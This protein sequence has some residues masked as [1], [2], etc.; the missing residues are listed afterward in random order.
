MAAADQDTRDVLDVHTTFWQAYAERDLDRR[1]AVCAPDVTFIGTGPHEKATGLAQYRAMNE[2]GVEQFPRP[3]VIEMPRLDLRLHGDVA[4]VECESV[5]KKTEADRCVVDE[6]RLTTVIKR[7]H[8]RWL[9]AHVHGSTPDYRLHDGEYMMREALRD[10]NLQLEREV[11]ERTRE[12]QRAK[13]AA[14]DLLMNILPATVIEELH[15]KGRVAARAH[16]NVTVLFADFKDFTRHSERLSPQHLVDELNA[17]FTAF[18]H[19]LA[20]HQV[21]KIKT[22]GDAYLAVSGLPSPNTDHALVAVRLALEMRDFIQARNAA[23]GARGFDIRIGLHS[24]D[25]VAGVV[26]IHKYAYDIWGD[27]VNIAAR[28]QENCLPGHVNVSATTHLLVGDHF[29]CTYRGEVEA[30]NKGPLKMY[31]VEPRLAVL[32]GSGPIRHDG[33]RL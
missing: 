29:Q 21:E 14:D 20:A 12:L 27:T 5:W 3:F 7:I 23:P 17:C 33:D 22:V 28:M 15:R 24:G 1:F 2:K 26:G 19:M 31:F 13:K 25:V 9:V 16:Q 8:G 11:A 18:D 4:W 32:A 6:I 30:K 10:R